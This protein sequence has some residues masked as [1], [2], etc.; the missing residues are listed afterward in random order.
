MKFKLDLAADSYGDRIAMNHDEEVKLVEA[1]M[2]L[3]FKFSISYDKLNKRVFWIK[4]RIVI[5]E[6]EIN[7]LEELM[8]FISEYGELIVDEDKIVIYNDYIES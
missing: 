8:E 7:S 5:P 6:I 3:G 4:D 1:Y 2:K